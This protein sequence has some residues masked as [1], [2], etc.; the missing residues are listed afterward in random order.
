MHIYKG[1][2]VN[3]HYVKN[4]VFLQIRHWEIQPLPVSPCTHSKY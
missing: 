2:T 1:Q 4:V 3:Q